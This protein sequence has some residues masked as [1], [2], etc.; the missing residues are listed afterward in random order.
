MSA[1]GSNYNP[2]DY[3]KTG[4][5]A[6]IG[7]FGFSIALFFVLGFF[8]SD[9]QID[10]V[11]EPPKDGQVIKKL[12]LATVENPW[13]S[14]DELVAH[15]KKVYKTNCATCHGVSG[16]GDGPGS[17]GMAVRNLIEGNWNKGGDSITLYTTL[18]KGIEGTSMA[19]FAHIKPVSRWALVHY[20]RSITNNKVEDDAAAVEAFAKGQ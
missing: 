7:S 8:F 15:G 1:N 10:E 16:K 14:S 6:F 2:G 4:F 20:V 17:A 18:T 3:N 9:I 13:V 11:I 5:L 12:D 19:A